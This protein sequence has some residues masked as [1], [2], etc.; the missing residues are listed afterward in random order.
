[1]RGYV[2]HEEVG[3]SSMPMWMLFLLEALHHH[4]SALTFNFIHAVYGGLGSF[5]RL[6]VNV[7]VA[8]AFALAIQGDLTR[9]NLAEERGEFVLK[10]LVVNI[11]AEV[12]DE[13]VANARLPQRRIALRPHDAARSALK[14]TARNDSAVQGMKSTLGILMVVEVDVRVTEGPLQHG[15][16]TDAD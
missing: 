2:L 12:L 3:P 14:V 4:L 1:M 5:F 9:K 6:E 16:A 7:A 13:H 8:F 10:L 15:L 11:C